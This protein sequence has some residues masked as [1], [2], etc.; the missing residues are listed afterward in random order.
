MKNL[1]YV[2]LCLACLGI[3]YFFGANDVW[4]TADHHVVCWNKTNTINDLRAIRSAQSDLLH[5]IYGNGDNEV[6][7]D[8]V[9]STPEYWKLDSTLNAAGCGWEDFYYYDEY[10]A[11]YDDGDTIET[12]VDYQY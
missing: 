3:G 7:F 11:G 10:T 12:P 6:W 5:R 9:M 4:F 2:V 1:F 8:C